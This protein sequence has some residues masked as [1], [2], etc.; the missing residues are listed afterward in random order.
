MK[1]KFFAKR[2]DISHTKTHT[3][4]VFNWAN[5]YFQILMA[6]CGSFFG[7]TR[8]LEKIFILGAN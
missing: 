1:Y 7:N 2:L 3:V 4:M 8:K 5:V 6:A